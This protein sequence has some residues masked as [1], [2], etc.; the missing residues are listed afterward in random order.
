MENLTVSSHLHVPQP[1]DVPLFSP[2]GYSLAVD[3]LPVLSYRPALLAVPTLMLQI[4]Q[5]I[6]HDTHSSALAALFFHQ[7]LAAKEQQR[8]HIGY[9]SRISCGSAVP[10]SRYP[11]FW[12]W[13]SCGSSREYWR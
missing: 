4:R 12:S 6:L 1:N 9:L 13:R 2:H 7:C 10:P 3:D 5:V 11:V 8:D